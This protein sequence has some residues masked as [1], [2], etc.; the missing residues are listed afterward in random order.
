MH[1]DDRP[2]AEELL[3]RYQLRDAAPATPRDED[4]ATADAAALPRRGRL[5]IYLGMAAGVGKTYAMLN[6][7]RRREARGTDVVIGIVE[8]HNRSLTIQQ[9]GDLEIIPRR[10]V[11]YRGTTLA[12][13]DTAAIIARQ[14][15]V[16]LVDELA[17]TNAPGSAHLKRYEDVEDLLNAGITVIAT[18]N[19]QH[20]A[21]LNDIV[22]SITGVRQR[23]TVPDSVLDNA[24]EIELVD[25]APDALRS[26]MRH[27]NIYP[28]EKAQMALERYFTVGNL[29]ALRELSLRR[30]AEKTEDQLEVL[31][32]GRDTPSQWGAAATERVMVCFDDKPHAAQVVRA[33]W[34]LA[35]GLKA[36]LLAVTVDV[37]HRWVA[38]AG[39]DEISQLA[40]DL[41]AE[42]IYVSGPD[43]AA[44]LA[45]VAREHHV[46]Q[47]VIGQPTRTP[48]QEFWRPSVVNRLLRLPLGAAIHI[49]PRQV[50]GEE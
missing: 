47:V 7:G 43:I 41:G 36:P 32:R 22:E 23:E 12:E 34:R 46:T 5:R 44:A 38:T 33:G 30:M 3:D 29:T 50:A 25:I 20:L 48:W 24:D 35:R 19:I 18:L 21:G 26:R 2:S 42:V 14:P 1:D 4:D 45:R 9:I 10:M 31:M 13:M 49:V 16:V 6:E 40:A 17:H 15:Q 8:T 11:A 39:H 28:Q 27:G 37:P